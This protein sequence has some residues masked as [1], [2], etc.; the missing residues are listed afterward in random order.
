[1]LNHDTKILGSGM[2]GKVFLTYNIHNP[3]H[4]VAIKRMNKKKHA[5]HL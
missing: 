4:L 1:M 2:Y 3:K 5:D